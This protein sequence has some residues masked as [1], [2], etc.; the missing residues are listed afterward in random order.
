MSPAD[1][2]DTLETDDF[3]FLEEVDDEFS[4]DSFIDAQPEPEADND[5]GDACKI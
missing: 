3:D 4:T 5:C 2:R 1:E